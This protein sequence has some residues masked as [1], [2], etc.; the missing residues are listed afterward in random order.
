MSHQRRCT[1]M[2]KCSFYIKC[3]GNGRCN[4]Y[5]CISCNVY[6]IRSLYYKC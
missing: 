3:D 1:G 2:N 6:F 5:V 4:K